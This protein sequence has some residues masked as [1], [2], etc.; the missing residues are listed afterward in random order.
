MLKKCY[1]KSRLDFAISN[2]EQDDDY[3]KQVWW[4]DESKMELYAHNDA[5]H[6]W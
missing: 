5:T 3:F 2:L 4:S 6:V 1:F